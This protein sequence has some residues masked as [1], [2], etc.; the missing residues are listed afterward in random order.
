MWCGFESTSHKHTSLF[1]ADDSSSGHSASSD[2]SEFCLSQEDETLDES[3]ELLSTEESEIG[4]Q[5]NLDYCPTHQHQ[6][7]TVVSSVQ[8]STSSSTLS[9]S[10]VEGPES[11]EV[12]RSTP[13]KRSNTC[14]HCLPNQVSFMELSQLE[15]IV[16]SINKIRGSRTSKCDGNLVPIFHS[17]KKCWFGCHIR[18][19]YNGCRSKQAVF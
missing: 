8:S 3:A 18:F 14:R 1:S 12:A 13:K 2:T 16:D 11:E 9:V 6:C 10:V 5:D 19:G 17:C 7:K 4:C 15:M